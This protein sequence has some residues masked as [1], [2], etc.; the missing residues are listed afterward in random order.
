[1]LHVLIETYWNVNTDISDL[2]VAQARGINRNIL[3]CKCLGSGSGS[4]L[5]LLVLIETYWNVNTSAES[6][7][8]VEDYVLIETY[9]NVNIVENNLIYNRYTY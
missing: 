4:G 1:M 5:G 8:Q 6:R 9:W 2:K 3:E 7:K